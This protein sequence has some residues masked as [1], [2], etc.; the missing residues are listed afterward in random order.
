MRSVT[1]AVDL[2]SL[3]DLYDK[4]ENTR[5]AV[6]HNI[7]ILKC[8]RGGLRMAERHRIAFDPRSEYW[9]LPERRLPIAYLGE[10]WTGRFAPASSLRAVARRVLL[11]FDQARID[12]VLSYRG[13]DYEQAGGL[14]K[15]CEAL[16]GHAG[17]MPPIPEWQ[18]LREV[19]PKLAESAG[20]DVATFLTAVPAAE[21][22]DPP[23]NR[24][25]PW[26]G[27]LGV[28]S[29]EDLH[30]RQAFFFGYGNLWTTTNAY[31]RGGAQQFASVIQNT[32]TNR[33]LDAA[34]QWATGANPIATKFLVLGRDDED[35]E[36]QDRSLIAPVLEVY[37]FLNLER[38][39]FYNNRAE[40]YRSW[41]NL[42]HDINP[43][44]LTERVGKVTADWLTENPAAVD[45]LGA[46]FNKIVDQPWTTRVQLEAVESP[47]V[48]KKAAH[49][50]DSLLDVQ[51]FEELDTIA[52]SELMRLGD[53]DIAAMTL[54]LLL[55]SKLYLESA[56]AATATRSGGHVE[57]APRPAVLTT[58][59]RSVD[60]APSKPK[61]LP[62]TLR[63]YGERAL[64]YIKAGFH[65]LF[66]GAPGTGKT[67]LAQFVGCAWDQSLEV[68]PEQMSADLAPLTT[69]GNS[70]WSPFHTIGGLVPTDKG[71][72][73]SHAGIFIDPSTTGSKAWRLRDGALVL[74]EMNRADLDRCIGELYPLLS[75]SVERVSPAGL[76]GVESIEMSPRFRVLATV[77]D[78][79]LDDI[80]FP[81]SEGLARRFQRIELPSASRDDLL[82]Y[83]GLDEPES[84]QN[85]RRAAAYEAVGTFFEVAR[86]YNLL[87]KAEDDERLP[88]GVAY[89][90][91]LRAWVDGQLEVPLGEET[92]PEQARDLLARSLRTLGRTKKW[93]E[94]LHAFLTKG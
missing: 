48:A 78:A 44:E 26:F 42:P 37:G 17:R 92:L 75:G 10:R 2:G 87:L 68:L 86:E 60:S 41:F 67:T 94:A 57:S 64:A 7:G 50:S 82:A 34:L 13:V 28:R 35:D 76:P 43:Y 62:P 79:H 5:S 69:V 45:A 8:I 36:P 73:T 18:Q 46:L 93:T 22:W 15:I 83:L 52:K 71:A 11:H 9:R 56:A 51:L 77:N 20:E 19:W 16:A 40:I 12:G 70:A 81:I 3:L 63:I 29:D 6:S 74:D 30:S 31:T 55:D 24:R 58:S 90:L 1:A 23:F 88:F 27:Y 33:M 80:V 49:M 14:D 54:H 4:S 85:L 65:V 91:P 59:Q 89:L 21:D 61:D 32:V 47:K 53:R 38:A 25:F 66:A 84:L 72:F 39:P